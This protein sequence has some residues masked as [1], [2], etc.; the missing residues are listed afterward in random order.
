MLVSRKLIQ[1]WLSGTTGDSRTMLPAW[2]TIGNQLFSMD[3][4][5][6]LLRAR[7]SSFSS[8][9]LP[10]WSFAICFLLFCLHVPHLS[11]NKAE[12]FRWASVIIWGFC[13]KGSRLKRRELR[14]YC[15]QKHEKKVLMFRLFIA[16]DKIKGLGLPPTLKWMAWYSCNYQNLVQ[17][18]K[19]SHVH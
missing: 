1:S 15:C 10:G 5:P 16:W 4:S 14:C 7:R 11:P 19:R 3:F 2:E 17:R 6:G 18:Q 13:W 12:L 9:P 8:I